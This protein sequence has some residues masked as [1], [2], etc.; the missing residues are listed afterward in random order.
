LAFFVSSRL[1]ELLV[2]WLAIAGAAFLLKLKSAPSLVIE[3]AAPDGLLRSKTTDVEHP[4]DTEH[5]SDSAA[6]RS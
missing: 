6:E 4:A 3:G 5:A 1:L 2:R